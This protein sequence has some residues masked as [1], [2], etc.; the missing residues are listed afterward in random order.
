MTLSSLSAD[1]SPF[2][3]LG[4]QAKNIHA[5]DRGSPFLKWPKIKKPLVFTSGF[6]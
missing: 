3:G 6:S 1:N 4:C 5:V 2:E